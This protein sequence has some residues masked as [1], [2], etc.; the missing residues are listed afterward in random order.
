MLRRFAK[1]ES[2][3]IAVLSAIILVVVIGFSGLVVDVGY[4]AAVKRQL[5]SAADAAALAGCQDLAHHASNETIWATVVDYAGRNFSR[6]VIFT[7]C[8]VV[9]PQTGGLSDIGSNY[10]KVTVQSNAPTFLSRVFGEETNLIQAQS[11]ARIGYLSGART[12]VPW[13]LPLLHATGISIAAGG[14]PEGWLTNQ[15]GGVWTGQVPAGSLGSVTVRAYNGQTLDPSYPNGVPEVASGAG[16]VI[17]LPAAGPFTGLSI[18]RLSG[19]IEHAGSC[20]FTAGRGESVVVYATIAAPLAAGESLAVTFGNS[21]ITMARVTDTL[22]RAAFAAPLAD[23]LQ[24]DYTFGVKH[25]SGGRTLTA[26]AVAGGF[27]VRRS[28]FPVIDVVLQPSVLTSVN[29]GPVQA[30]VRLNDYRY[31][32]RYELKVTGGQAEVG[33]YMAID[34]ST[35]RHTPYWRH[36]Q[37][38]AEYPSMPSGTSTNYYPYVAGTADFPFIMHLGDAVWTQPGNLSGPSTRDAL[39]E[40]FAGESANFAAWEA[41]GRPPSRRLVLVPVV[42]KIQQTTGSTPLRIISFA[43]FYVEDVAIQGGDVDVFGRFVEYTAPSVDVVDEPPGS[44]VVE[45]VHLSARGLDF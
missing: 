40:R 6:P 30:T 17:R 43:T 18:A 20:M 42:E 10:V 14:G 45:A 13:G 4:W 23:N 37:D 2:G 38:P 28:T 5:Q 22:Y 21:D 39:V 31:G 35:L 26:V 25:K 41:G 1:D 16:S 29:A 27:L 7:T 33:N 11:I 34:F 9:P 12:P 3:A 36:P 19:G 15:G 32:E 24:S 44:L 8:S